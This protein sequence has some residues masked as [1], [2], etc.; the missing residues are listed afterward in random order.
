MHLDADFWPATR[1]AADFLLRFLDPESGLP[2]ASVDL[3][4]QQ[5]GQHAYTAASVVGGLKAAAR[6]AAAPR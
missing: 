3:W 1:R 6:A 4:E 2:K 5:D